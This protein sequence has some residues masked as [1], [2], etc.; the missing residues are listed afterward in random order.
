MR[1]SNLFWG[2]VVLL[3]GLLLLLQNLGLLGAIRIWELFWPVLLVSAGIWVLW[4]ALSKS[5]VERT[6]LEIP[7][8]GARQ[9]EVKLQYGAGRL[10]IG[11]DALSAGSGGNLARGD[12]GG[13]VEST[14]GREGELLRATL[15]LPSHVFP[16]FWLPQGELD[17]TLFLCS[18]IPLSLTVECGAVDARLNLEGLLVKDLVY[19][20][21]ASSN[22]IL[23][24][25]RAGFTRAKI[26]VG[27]ANLEVRIP[28]GVAARVK[29]TT[30]IGANSVNTARFPRNGNEYMS[31]DWE[32]AENKIEIKIDGGVGSFSVQ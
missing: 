27:A 20:S 25:S 32:T 6:H 18:E 23:M 14:I 19:K 7:L 31:P 16:T 26:E 4:G 9:A 28:Q 30:G 12:F 11:A 15:K 8:E 17:W 29:L 22:H 3:L 10:E 1:R 2:L 5:K 21:G 13:G 24:P